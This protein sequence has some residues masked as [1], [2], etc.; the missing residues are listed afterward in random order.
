M[1]FCFSDSTVRR[2][3]D[4]MAE[5]QLHLLLQAVTTLKALLPA[6]TDSELQQ[7]VRKLANDTIKSYFAI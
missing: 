5:E 1:E 3:V 7:T 6:I 2:N 4:S